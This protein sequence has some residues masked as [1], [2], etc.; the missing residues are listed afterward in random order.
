[1]NTD[2]AAAVGARPSDFF[3]GNKFSNSQPL[4]VFKILDHT[5][6]VSG[7]ISF[8]HVLHTFAGKTVAF[9]TKLCIPLLKDFA[10]F[11][12]APEGAD[13]FI[14]IF[15]PA[16]WAGVLVSQI[17]H[18][19]AAVHPAGSDERDIGHHVSSSRGSF[20]NSLNEERQSL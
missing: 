2:H 8:I 7:S 12:F 17:S 15:H 20:Q 3:V 19:S 18:A 14:G 1:V 4:D 6:V 16:T 11:D 5:H 10:V 13:G 9:K